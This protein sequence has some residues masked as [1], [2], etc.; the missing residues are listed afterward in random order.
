V[1]HGRDIV[2]SIYPNPGNGNITLKI[3]GA[4]HGNVV[5]QVLDQQGRVLL[6]KPFG[7][8]HTT[9]FSMPMDVRYLPKGNY[10]LN[11]MV[12][13]KKYLHKLLVQ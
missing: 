8:Q 5:V 3:Q 1:Q 4:I 6:T 13:G 10:I 12:E 2:S 7:H 9:I 11:I